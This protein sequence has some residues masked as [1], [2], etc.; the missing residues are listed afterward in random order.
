MKI[1]YAQTPSLEKENMESVLP[2]PEPY[3][4]DEMEKRASQALKDTEFIM[5]QKRNRQQLYENFNEYVKE[6][7]KVE[8]E[9]ARSLEDL[10]KAQIK[11]QADVE[12]RLC[13]IEQ[14]IDIV[15]C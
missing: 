7:L 5:Q 6:R 1:T 12:D 10:A 8:R 3:R 15:S 13:Y 9:T 14:F 11:T 2:A 4:E